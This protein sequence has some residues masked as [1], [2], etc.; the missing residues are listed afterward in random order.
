MGVQGYLAHKKPSHPGTQ[1][2][3]PKQVELTDAR[4]SVR[5]DAV[6]ELIKAAEA[7]EGGAPWALAALAA[8][9]GDS[10]ACVREAAVR[11]LGGYA[12]H[13][14]FHVQRQQLK[15]F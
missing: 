7:S 4:A 3:T 9:L 1:A 2:C 10:M 5:K 6:A 8:R 11:G 12:P 14:H 13:T 15:T